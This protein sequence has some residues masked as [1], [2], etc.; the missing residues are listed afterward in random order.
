MGYLFLCHVKASFSSI[1]PLS[2]TYLGLGCG[3]SS[4]S[5]D[6]QASLS[7]VTSSSSSRG[8]LNWSIHKPAKRYNLSSVSWLCTRV[9][10]F[11]DMPGTPHLGHIL[12]RMKKGMSFRSSVA[13][14]G[15]MSCLHVNNFHKCMWLDKQLQRLWI[16][17]WIVNTS[18]TL[19]LR[20]SVSR[21]FLHW[22]GLVL[23]SNMPICQWTC[24]T[25]YH[26]YC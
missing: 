21:C 8:I 26:W 17:I 24:L 7:L 1:N 15:L 16:H 22:S 18:W 10:S 25:L 9:S 6:A 11:L 19:T 20:L 5:R 14:S 3:G 23:G 2:T 13:L 12:N 4:L